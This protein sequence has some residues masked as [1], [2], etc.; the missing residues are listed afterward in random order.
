[1]NDV[2]TKLNRLAKAFLPDGAELITADE[3]NAPRTAVYS[4]DFD[5]DRTPE[6]AAAYRLNGE[7]HIVVLRYRGG[8]WEPAAWAK[9][10]GSGVTLLAAA[11]V[12]G[13]GRNQLIVGWQTG[14][15]RS[16]LSVYEWTREGLRDAAPRDLVYS[17]I[18][19]ADMPGRAGRDGRAELALWIHDTDDAFRVEVLRWT[20]G[21]FVPA[22]DAYPHY[23]P[24]VVR[25]YERLTRTHPD[26]SFYWY[27]LADAQYRAGMATAARASVRRALGFSQPYPSR[28]ALLELERS[29]GGWMPQPGVLT[30]AAVLLPASVK[31]AG[32]TKWGYID[33]SGR[34][35]IRPQ[36]DD[37]REFQPNGLAVVGK[38]GRYGLIDRSG[39]FV[40]QPIYGSISPFSEGRAVV[41]DDEGFKVIDEAGTVI[42]KRAYPFIADMS[43]GRAVFYVMNG[44]GSGGG[45]G[46]AGAGEIRYGYLDLQGNEV[47]PAQY[48]SAED[49][50]GGK[51]VVK[52]KEREYAL[53]DPNGRKLASY[54]YAFVGSPGDGLLPF[55]QEE[56]GKY[57]Y[58]DERG[59]V[60]ISPVYTG[61]FPFRDGRAVVYMGEDFKWNYGVIDKRGRCVVRPEYNDIRQLGER[62]LALGR[63]I[64]SERPYIGSLYAIADDSGKLLSG[65]DYKDVSDFKDGLASVS[66]T[67]ETYFID[68]SG[69]P[70][71]G[72]PRVNGSGT[73][74]LAD[75][76]IRADVDRRLSYLTRAGNVVWR[77]NTTIPL[78][79]PY[80]VIEEKY[81]PNPDYLVYYP[82]LE[83]MPD[84]G[85]QRTVNARLRELSQVK[86]VPGGQ[87][88]YSY[89]GDFEVAFYKERLLELELEGYHFPFGAAHGMPTRT[90]VPIDLISG[91]IYEL[92]DLFKPGSSYVEVLSA[93]VGRQIREDPQ[94]SYVFPDSYKGIR[95]DQPFYVT[96]DALHL[97]FE[98]YEIAPYAAGFPTF[99]IPFA[100]IMDLIDTEGAFWRS[101]HDESNR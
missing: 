27:Y 1:M 8:A 76:L 86:P 61:A 81:K 2:E 28:G 7:P 13:T 14:S 82:Q 83:G 43:G 24:G 40:V 59:N 11:P 78:T 38:N 93:I 54:P 30:R 70:A 36:Y 75:G 50:S 60:V 26:D 66:D 19:I 94:Y 20:N 25:H 17:D 44:E 37:A 95:A 15:F 51:A 63:A 12:L 18:H 77:Q 16:K 72:Y 69:K 68:R 92:R 49:F 74:A 10:P 80:A 73:L 21:A 39:R 99:T 91:T 100:E 35:A 89:D 85:A 48:E 98:P 5:G 71:P 57:G 97:Y 56:D 79:P 3:P 87:L 88:D 47:I 42:T 64:D 53:I 90:Y 9:G 32:G 23:F 58:I 45:E 84:A 96:E 52:V 4:A 67:S 34:M 31:T 65:F 41:I 101:F 46:G 22:P 33:E 6:V 55:R 62:R 29:I